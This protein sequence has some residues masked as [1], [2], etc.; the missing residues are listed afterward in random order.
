MNKHIVATLLCL[1]SCAAGAAECDPKPGRKT[2]ENKCG[3]CHVVEAGAPHTVGPNLHAIVGR[4]I[5]QAPGFSF[6]EPLAKAAGQW[7]VQRLDEFLAAPQQAFP[8]TAMP[9]QGLKAEAERQRLICYL[10]TLG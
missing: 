1:V 4:S 5:G 6:A 7:S 3:I 8:G 10:Q 9:F 2:F